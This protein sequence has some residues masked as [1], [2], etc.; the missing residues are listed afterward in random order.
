ME[1]NK[2]LPWDGYV[3]INGDVHVKRIWGSK[4]SIDKD[5]PFV[6]MYLG[7]VQASNREEAVNLLIEEA[8]IIKG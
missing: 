7:P 8:R 1:I 2:K 3:H 6:Y 5:S 4:S